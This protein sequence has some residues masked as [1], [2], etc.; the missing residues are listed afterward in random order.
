MKKQ[1]SKNNNYWAG[2]FVLLPILALVS[3]GVGLPVLFESQSL[4]YKFGI[5]KA[6]LQWGKGAGVLALILMVYQGVLVSRFSFLERYLSLK[7]SFFIHKTI[8]IVIGILVVVHPILI[9]GADG[10]VIFPFELRYWPEFLGMFLVVLVLSVA[11]LALGYKALKI[12]ARLRQTL[13]R[14]G[15]PAIIILALVHAGWV[16]ETFDIVLPGIWLGLISF[17]ILGLFARIYLKRFSK[18]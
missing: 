14:M 8:G 1:I 16:S 6:M 17:I 2:F 10:F 12:K 15:T 4:Y 11:G 13:H 7:Q 9:L 3:S 5:E 18:K